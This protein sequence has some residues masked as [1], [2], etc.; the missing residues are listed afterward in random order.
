MYLHISQCI[1]SWQCNYS[2][3]PIFTYLSIC[4][5][6]SSH[7]H[8]KCLSFLTHPHPLLRSSLFLVNMHKNVIIISLSCPGISDLLSFACYMNS[9][10][11]K[12]RFIFIHIM[13]RVKQK[14]KETKY[15]WSTKSLISFLQWIASRLIL[16]QDCQ[17]RARTCSR[18]LV[19]KFLG[20]GKNSRTP[21]YVRLW[22]FGYDGGHEPPM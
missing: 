19:V 12:N 16:D 1:P 10:L 7:L 2:Y 22:G 20:V 17:R 5:S 4:L 14:R 3:C 18:I 8:P 11:N 15:N 9:E 13:N 21:G 6:S